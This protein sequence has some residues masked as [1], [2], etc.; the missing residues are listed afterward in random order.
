[1]QLIQRKTDLSLNAEGT[2]T[3]F[4]FHIFIGMGA[5][6]LPNKSVLH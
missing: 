6:Y 1:M 3:S 4:I 5:H 2:P